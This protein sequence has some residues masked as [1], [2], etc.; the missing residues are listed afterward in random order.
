MILSHAILAP[1]R[2][3]VKVKQMGNI[4]SKTSILVVLY[5]TINCLVHN[6]GHFEFQ[7]GHHDPEPCQ[8]YNTLYARQSQTN[9]QYVGLICSLIVLY[10]IITCLVYNIGHF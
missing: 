10:L 2:S 5:L 8:S 9:K 4:L 6:I 7:D 3:P 1:P